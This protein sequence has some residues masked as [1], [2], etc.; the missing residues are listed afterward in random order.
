MNKRFQLTATSCR[1]GFTM[2]ELTVAAALLGTVFVV[3]VPLLKHVRVSRDAAEQ[4]SVAQQEA[5]NIME[6]LAVHGSSG[7]QD[8][9]IT[10]S[11]EAA[12]HL[13]DGAVTIT[14]API[15]EGLQQVTLRVTWSNAVGN[16][17]APV[18]LTAWFPAEESRP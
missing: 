12:S 16:R 1:D 9:M 6:R 10:L 17:P 7:A 4:Q 5:A 3:T 15:V 13:P 2:L 8:E 14:R 11:P 18:T